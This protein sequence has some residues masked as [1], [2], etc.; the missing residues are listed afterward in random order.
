VDDGTRTHDGRNHNPGLYQLSYVHHRPAC[1]VPF[2]VRP[3][4]IDPFP[5]VLPHRAQ[6]AR[7]AGL[8]LLH[9]WP[10]PVRDN[11]Q[12]SK[13]APC[14]FVEPCDADSSA[15][16]APRPASPR[17]SGAP[18]RTRTCDPRLRRP[19]LYP[20]ELRAQNPSSQIVSS[21]NVHVERMVGARGFEPPTLCS[22]SRCATRLRYTPT[23]TS[24]R[25]SNASR[26]SEA[27]PAGAANHTCEVPDRQFETRAISADF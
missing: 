5:L 18:G 22:Q 25:Y 19:M 7:P 4:R 17:S 26:R 12:L 9:P 27:A 16:A 23:E 14:D 15:F 10:A 2:P 3:K 13:I 1:D 6:V 21:L 20:A 8:R 24:L 11:L